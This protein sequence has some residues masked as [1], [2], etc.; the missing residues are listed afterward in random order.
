MSVGE[1]IKKYR[2][3]NKLTQKQLAGEIGL[4]E[5]TIRRYEKEERPPT[6]EVL[7]KIATALEIPLYK[8][9][10]SNEESLTSIEKANN[11]LKNFNPYDSKTISNNAENA[12]IGFKNILAYHHLYHNYNF[13]DE[14]LLDIINSKMIHDFLGNLLDLYSK[15]INS[16]DNK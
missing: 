6:I 13:S 15:N 5:I 1:N 3:E 7:N 4:S 11:I 10:S 2:K 12:L 14:Q 8:L 9:T 16:N